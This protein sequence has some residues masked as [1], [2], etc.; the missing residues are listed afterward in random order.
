VRARTRT[1]RTSAQFGHIGHIGR[2]RTN[3]DTS[4]AQICARA[5]H[6]SSLRAR[7]Q[8]TYDFPY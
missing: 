7:T 3:T 5:V 4:G 6:T 8:R 2:I 1:P